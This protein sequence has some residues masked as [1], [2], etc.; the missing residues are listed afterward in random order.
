MVISIKEENQ[1]ILLDGLHS[2]PNLK[3]CNRQEYLNLFNMN[4]QS[5][6]LK[7]IIA[8][9]A[10]NYWTAN[11]LSLNYIVGMN[12]IEAAFQTGFETSPMPN[13]QLVEDFSQQQDW[14][15]IRLDLEV[16]KIYP[17]DGS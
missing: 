10:W 6:I 7:V 4:L 11:R 3:G 15:S 2:K 12:F 17:Y 1:P 9:F 14:Q 8:V 16:I 5:M 13:A